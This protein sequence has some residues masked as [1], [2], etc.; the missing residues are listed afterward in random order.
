MEVG[1]EGAVAGHLWKPFGVLLLWP[2]IRENNH[3]LSSYLQIGGSS[4]VG[5]AGCG[6]RWRHFSS[7]GGE[8]GF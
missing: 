5:E 3:S 4:R 8:A 2:W 7:N 1:G 6:G